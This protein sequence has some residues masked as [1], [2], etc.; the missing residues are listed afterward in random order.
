M[1]NIVCI[2]ACKTEPMFVFPSCGAFKTPKRIVIVWWKTIGYTDI[3]G[4]RFHTMDIETEELFFFCTP[5]KTMGERYDQYKLLC[6]RGFIN[7]VNV[8]VYDIA[9]TGCSVKAHEGSVINLVTYLY[10]IHI[11]Y[12]LYTFYTLSIIYDSIYLPSR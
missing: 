10:I 11:T 3:E 6:A 7:S 5:Y 4:T 9:C 2:D 1:Y 8:R 12:I